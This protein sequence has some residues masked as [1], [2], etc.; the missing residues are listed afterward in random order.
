MIRLTRLNA[1]FLVFMLV[2]MSCSKSPEE[3]ASEELVKLG[4]ALTVD[5][6]VKAAAKGDGTAVNWFL[7]GGMSADTK[8]ASGQTVLC[9]AA[10]NA[11]KEIV[12]NLLANGADVNMNE[13]I[14][15]C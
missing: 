14:L 10:A 3:V 6:F 1:L 9:A 13:D 8:D 12:E 11:H 2:V 5:D 7:M 15:G 4:F